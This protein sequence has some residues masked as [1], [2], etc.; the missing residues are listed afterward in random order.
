MRTL[1]HFCRFLIGVD[2]PH[3]QVTNDELS[4][5]VAHAKYADM[6]VEIG[7]YEGK[8]SVELAGSTTGTVYSV[9]TF[10][11]GRLGICYGELIAKLHRRRRKARNLRLVKADSAEAARAFDGVL[12]MLFIDADHSYEG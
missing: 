6:V 9:D 11:A 3:S 4:E 1:V 8:T 2:A 10:P 12:D 7:C 5:L